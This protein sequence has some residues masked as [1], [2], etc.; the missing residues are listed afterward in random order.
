MTFVDLKLDGSKRQLHGS[1]KNKQVNTLNQ[2][3]KKPILSNN[4]PA[5]SLPSSPAV[6]RGYAS[7]DP[8]SGYASTSSF[9]RP[10]LEGTLAKQKAQR[11]PLLHLLAIRPT[12]ADLIKEKI[13]I[14]QEECLEILQKVGKQTSDTASDWQITDR[15]F[16][17]LDV[18]RFP[19]SSQQ[20]RQSA[21]DNAIRAYDRL[22]VSKEDELWQLLLPSSERGKGKTLS[23]LHLNGGPSQQPSNRTESDC[24][25]AAH[26]KQKSDQSSLQ[27]GT[28]GETMAGSK[29]QN[30]VKAKK[31]SEKEAQSKRLMSTKPAV[32]KP[33]TTAP[34]KAKSGDE[35]AKPADDRKNANPG[36]EERNS[37]KVVK[38]GQ[39]RKA[40]SKLLSTEF[41]NDSDEEE[42]P[43]IDEILA[44]SSGSDRK[45]L[46]TNSGA[47]KP[48]AINST[49]MSK[50]DGATPKT[51]TTLKDKESTTR[52][53]QKEVEN[54]VEKT[55]NGIGGKP[56]PN[57]QDSNKQVSNRQEREKQRSNGQDSNKHILNGQNK[58]KQLSNGQNKEKQLS[59]GQNMQKQLSNGQDTKK[60]MSNGQDR[61]KQMPNGQDSMKQ[62]TNNK[63]N[64]KPGAAMKSAKESVEAREKPTNVN[65]TAGKKQPSANDNI[66]PKPAVPS[67]KLVGAA[68][69][70]KGGTVPLKQPS[71]KPTPAMKPYKPSE[72]SSKTWFSSISGKPMSSH[73]PSSSQ[74]SNSSAISTSLPSAKKRPAENESSISAPESKRRRMSTTPNKPSPLGSSPQNASDH[75]GQTPMSPPADRL[76]SPPGSS[77][78]GTESL[79]LLPLAELKKQTSDAFFDYVQLRR[80]LE[81]QGIFP[82][83]KRDEA[84]RNTDAQPL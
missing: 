11:F 66:A 58:E 74:S 31:L 15:W 39:K 59:N 21:I 12:S 18:W 6:D 14:T 57:G 77:L 17:E 4:T 72:P 83:A 55:V 42:S 60:Q 61:E 8:R 52:K 32:S 38:A 2:L 64:A 82:T 43:D 20:D 29:F 34:R 7:H 26:V 75:N 35:M 5:R 36:D 50:A 19:Y 25:A 51:V 1:G 10:P 9:N 40:A 84:W 33:Q 80:A 22:R 62:I 76:T 13:H 47:A 28:G 46:K 37:A 30:Q 73:R 71:A 70:Q 65:F 23:K 41:V 78:V 48:N 56:M 16:K 68:E 67:T 81:D 3:L 79:P 49:T 44:L 24:T 63:S 53:H 69:T 45:R 54:S 27:L